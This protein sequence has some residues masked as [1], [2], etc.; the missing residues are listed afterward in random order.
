MASSLDFLSKNIKVYDFHV[1]STTFL[2]NTCIW[3]MQFN[4]VD[5]NELIRQQVKAEMAK[6]NSGCADG[7]SEG[8][9]KTHFSVSACAGTFSGPIGGEKAG[10]ICDAGWHVCNG[11]DV[12]EAELT[13]SDRSDLPG[14]Y[15]FD[16][17]HDCGGCWLTCSDKPKLSAI[18]GYTKGCLDSGA[19]H[20][21]G[22]FGAGCTF[23]TSPSCVSTKFRSDANTGITRSGCNIKSIPAG[24]GGVL[25]CKDSKCPSTDDKPT[26]Y[27]KTKDACLPCPSGH[28][29]NG[30]S[31]RKCPNNNYVEK[32]GCYQCPSGY[33]CNGATKTKISESL[34]HAVP[35]CI[36]V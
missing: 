7:S 24:K 32:N 10:D 33:E 6:K 14:C 31:A 18:N 11:L 16:S 28:T 3:I 27:D 35:A 2:T 22:A 25:C 4:G 8:L 1:R 13:L 5:L 30:K 21:I 9:V 12:W 15:V 19:G 17:M 34:A 20:D 29:C 23:S 26:F 36:R